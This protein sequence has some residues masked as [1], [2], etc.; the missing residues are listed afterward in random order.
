MFYALVFKVDLHDVHEMGHLGEDEHS[1]SELLQF[2]EDAINEFEFTGGAE[3]P[4]VVADIVVVS[5]EH[6]GVVAALA[7]LHHKVGEGGRGHLS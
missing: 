7:Q 4:V 5:E 6:V 2:G 1:M 3:D